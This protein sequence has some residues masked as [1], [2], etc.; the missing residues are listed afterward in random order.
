MG[1]RFAGLILRSGTYH[2]VAEFYRSLGLEME[3][4]QH[5]GPKHYGS[6]QVA[7]A[8]VVEVYRRSENFPADAVMVAVDSLEAALEAVG[9]S[10]RAEIRS[11]G[12]MRFAYVHDPDGRPVMLMQDRG[13]A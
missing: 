2:D 10:G 3:E 6:G 12:E 11:G 13:P 1:A 8:F 9:F 4:H 5:G 7:D